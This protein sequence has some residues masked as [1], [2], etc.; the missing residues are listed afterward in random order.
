LPPWVWISLLAVLCALLAILQYRWTG[1]IA[2]A[3]RASLR[4]DLQQRLMTATRDFNNRISSAVREIVSNS[5]DP[6]SGF[7]AWSRTH[8]HYFA[9]VQL[10]QEPGERR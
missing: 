2:A 1:Q 10:E 6:E 4:E 5:S 7:A 9:S 3:E 8:P